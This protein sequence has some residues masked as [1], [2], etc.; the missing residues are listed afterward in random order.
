MLQYTLKRLLVAVLVALTVSV[1]NF[2]LLLASGDI[3]ASM[4]GEAASQAH[5][6]AIR[7]H[8]GFDQPLLVQYF[9]WL[10]KALTG[11]FG[12]SLYFKTPVI[13]IVLARL[14]VTM[15]LGVLAISFA[16]LLSIPLGVAAAV[17]PNGIVDRLVN[18]IAAIGQALPNFWFALM[19]IV[20]FSVT[21]SWLPPSGSDNWTHF[22]LPTIALGFH[23]S[24]ALIRLTR[25]GMLEVLASDYIRTARAKGVA[26]LSVF[27]KHALR[28]AIVPVVSL[29]AVQFGFMLGGSIVIESVFAL[30]GTGFLAWE[31]IR[32]GDIPVVQAVLLLFSLF[33]IVLTFI[34]DL[35]NAW[36]DPRIRVA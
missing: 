21:L 11:D 34:A 18:I 24:P 29:S 19:L 25:A 31:A 6:Q 14:P 28:N 4:A 2:S 5:I 8:Y 16:I 36:L 10:G 33:Y 7:S 13:D 3:A 9:S 27:F 22:V 17:R 20:L 26:P 12:Q 30:H 15:T 1:V 35:L 32:G 23:T